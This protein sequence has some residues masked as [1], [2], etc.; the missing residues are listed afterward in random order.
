MQIHFMIFSSALSAA[1]A[2]CAYLITECIM[3]TDRLLNGEIGM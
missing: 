2:D 3:K 1:T